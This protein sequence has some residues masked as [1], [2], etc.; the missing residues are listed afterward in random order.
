MLNTDLEY[1]INKKINSEKYKDYLPNGLQVEG[2]KIIKNIIT[3]VSACQ[4]LIDIAINC[5]SDA[6]IVHHGYFWK[7]ESRRIVGI[8]YQRLRKLL[9][10]N[11]NLYAWHLPLDIHNELGN[12]IQLA[13]KLGVENI[14]FLG[15]FAM[16][17]DLLIPMNGEN[18][19]KH[20]KSVLSC[21]NILHFSKNAPNIIKKISWC[22]GKGQDFIKLA[23]IK[24]MDAFISG[25][26]SEETMHL[27]KEGKI[28]FYSAGHHSTEK[29][30]I[31]ALGNW[32]TK[33][34]DLKINF[35]DIP[36]PV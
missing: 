27:A 19:K 32:L 15:K 25:E 3:G 33:K 16:Q 10:H 20:I 21:N 17:G 7:N 2:R 34:Y 30:G 1:E 35:I 24:K 22:V 36:N 29:I 9:S 13:K 28:H 14:S 31:K 8:K 11:I 6:I 18:F 26:V 4:E 5:D 23:I 12:N